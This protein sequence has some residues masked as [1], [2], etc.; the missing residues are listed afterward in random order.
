[1]LTFIVWLVLSVSLYFVFKKALG[2]NFVKLKNNYERMRQ[3]YAAL[4]LENK[5]LKEG[6]ADLDKI[7]EET[8]ALY[9]ITKDIC[10]S[11][12][13][14]K[15]FANFREQI[16]RYIKIDDCKFIKGPI[17]QV[18]G[19]AQTVVIP[20]NIDRH[21]IGFLAVSPVREEDRDKFNILSQQFL[22][23]LK[24]A[25]LYQRVQELTITDSLTGAFNRRFLMERLSEEIGRS[26]KF[27]YHFSFLMVDIDNFKDYNDHHGHLVGDVILKE[28]ASIIKQNI[29]QIDFLARYGGEEFSIIL[30]ETDRPAA[31]FVAERIRKALEG[32]SIKAYDESLKATLSIGISIFPDN[33]AE[34]LRL[35]D[36]ADQALY[37]AKSAGRNRIC[38]Y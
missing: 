36:T 5:N 12:D 21:Q 24:R 15:V 29:R 8:V 23:G 31:L 30:T 17:E 22:L 16:T 26:R 7:S 38:A 19:E 3:E 9:N 37:Q 4:L 28:A 33:A 2:Y 20:L 11:L 13:E 14:D 1:M 6:N 10:R 35:I 32:Q 27:N 34:V 18:K 25:I